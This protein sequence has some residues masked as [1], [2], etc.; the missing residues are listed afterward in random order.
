[1]MMI[2][3]SLSI[4]DILPRNSE[5]HLFYMP[6]ST[7]YVSLPFPVCVG[8]AQIG[9]STEVFPWSLIHYIM[10]ASPCNALGSVT[11][12]STLTFHIGICLWAH[13]QS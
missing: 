4:E 11:Y 5:I 7:V 9:V 6:A 3:L 10:V 13:V 2:N 1:M 12:L 8:V